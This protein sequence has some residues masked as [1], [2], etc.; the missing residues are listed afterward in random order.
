[1]LSLG[2]QPW[3]PTSSQRNINMTKRGQLPRRFNVLTKT[4]YA[5]KHLMCE[6]RKIKYVG[7]PANPVAAVYLIPAAAVA[8]TFTVSVAAASSATTIGNSI[9]EHKTNDRSQEGSS[10]LAAPSSGGR[11]T[12]VR[13]VLSPRSVLGRVSSLSSSDEHLSTTHQSTTQHE[14]EEK[15]G[16]SKSP[17][18]ENNTRGV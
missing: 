13:L 5:A 9:M 15:D 6:N 16:R 8:A 12:N 11:T 17:E 1:M 4:T 10:R 7:F 3:R 14:R 18:L 2:T